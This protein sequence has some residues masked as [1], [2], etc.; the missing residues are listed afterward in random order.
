[1]KPGRFV[2][3]RQVNPAN[4]IKSNLKEPEFK[5]RQSPGQQLVIRHPFSSK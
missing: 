1:M 2:Y 4:R 5:N 3:S